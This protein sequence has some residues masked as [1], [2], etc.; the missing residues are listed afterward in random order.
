MA[1]VYNLLGA[2]TQPS[3]FCKARAT[4]RLARLVEAGL[5]YVID[6]VEMTLCIV[7]TPVDQAKE[8]DL[9]EFCV[10]TSRFAASLLLRAAVELPYGYG[11][12]LCH[13]RRRCLL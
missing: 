10:S 9:A 4:R 7:W 6:G 1:T 2:A 13:R 8:A 11:R 3:G 5:G 12:R